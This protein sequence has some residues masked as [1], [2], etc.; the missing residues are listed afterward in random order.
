[1]PPRRLLPGFACAVVLVAVARLAGGEAAQA[2]RTGLT[3]VSCEDKAWSRV[4]TPVAALPGARLF[5]GEYQ[6]GVYQ[7]EVPDAWN[8]ELVLW[9]HGHVA[10]TGAG[11]L[12]LRAAHPPVRE[13]LIARGFAWAASSYRCNGYVPGQALIDTLLLK[14]LFPSLTGAGTPRRTLLFGA[15]MG[16]HA[17]L[18][19]A[20]V[21][22]DAVDGTLAIC[23]ATP[24]LMDFF[25]AVGAA[26]EAITGITASRETLQADLARIGEALGTPPAYTD[27][28]RRLASVQIHLSGGPRPFAMEGLERPFLPNIAPGVE[29]LVNP[30]ASPWYRMMSNSGVT[31]RIDEALGLDAGELN[32]RVRRKAAEPGLRDA[33]G[34]YREAVRL[35]GRIER[36]V[37]TM[38]TTG[39]LTT[40]VSLQQDL[41]R[42]VTAAGRDRWL[43]QRLYRA[44]GHCTFSP[45][46]TSAA[47]DDLVAWVRGGEMADGDSVLGDLSDAGRRFTTPLRPG[48]PGTLSA[49]AS[50][51]R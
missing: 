8:G 34:P 51:R 44:P 27:R 39:D 48:D 14:D 10:S 20:H 23:P 15:S 31:Y 11:G 50:G 21:W 42:A 32:A 25:S 18:V 47:I 2:P 41:R 1:M 26:A 16:G 49:V 28:G 3:P 6:G 37:L 13:A 4:S 40:P 22:P 43:V 33:S 30:S 9:A 38:H 24:E 17:A 12:V 35:D 45:E 46:E 7:I 19:G 29:A 36:P 5:S